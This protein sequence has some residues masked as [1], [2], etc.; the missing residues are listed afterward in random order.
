MVFPFL[1]IGE[2]ILPDVVSATNWSLHLAPEVNFGRGE[3]RREFVDDLAEL[4]VCEGSG[5]LHGLGLAVDGEGRGNFVFH[6]F[7]FLDFGEGDHLSPLRI[8]FYYNPK[9]EA[10]KKIGKMKFAG[11]I[12][13]EGFWFTPV[14]NMV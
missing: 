9:R 6:G 2:R 13:S 3:T 10:T 12:D 7:P 11:T 8:L 14:H 4:G 5:E 1:D